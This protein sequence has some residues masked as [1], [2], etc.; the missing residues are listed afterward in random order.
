MIAIST[1]KASTNAFN[2]FNNNQCYSKYKKC[3]YPSTN[4]IY[5]INKKV[6]RKIIVN[7]QQIYAYI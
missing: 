4:D 1:L 3:W 2:P 6:Y 7:L 5:K